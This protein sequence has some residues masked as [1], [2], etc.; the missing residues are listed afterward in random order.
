MRRWLP[1]P[2]LWVS[3]VGLW[4]LLNETLWIGHVLLGGVL[5]FGACVV[6]RRLEAPRA[7]TKGAA[8]ALRH[9]LVAAALARDVLVDIV[10]SNIAVARIVLNRGTRH[11]T[12]GFLDVP[13]ELRD[14]AGLAV[15]ACIITAT[16]GTVWARHDAERGILTL[17]ILDLIDEAAWTRTIKGRYEKR[18]LEIFE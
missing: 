13:L 15:L 3:L 2:L 14:P 12:A 8:V 10:R 17:H 11:A 5:A 18:L 6:F 7:E 9:T 16:P 1:F 4:L